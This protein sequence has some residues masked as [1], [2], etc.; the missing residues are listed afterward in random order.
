MSVT[1]TW[2]IT[3]INA[4][5]L[6]EFPQAVVQTYWKKVGTDENGFTGEFIGATPFREVTVP[7]EEF[8]PFDQ[9]TEEIVLEWIKAVVVGDYEQH[10]NTQIQKKIDQAKI[11][12]T[13]VAM[14]W[15]PEVTPPPMGN[16]PVAP[17]A[18]NP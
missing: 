8:V 12:A 15:A 5:N 1:Y 9:L 17:G 13:P 14:P 18:E 4:A 2:E 3:S 16:A 11:N 6:E 7:P 10:V